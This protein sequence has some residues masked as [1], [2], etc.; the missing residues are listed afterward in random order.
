MSVAVNAN[1]QVTSFSYDAA[2]NLAAEGQYTYAGSDTQVTDYRGAVPTDFLYYPREIW[3][4]AV[5]QVDAHF[6]EFSGSF[7]G[8]LVNG[9]SHDQHRGGLWGPLTNV[10]LPAEDCAT[11]R[12]QA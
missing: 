2:G 12:R 11:S 7:P 6:A 5:G 8:R 9:N 1:D 10:R 4:Y 3:S